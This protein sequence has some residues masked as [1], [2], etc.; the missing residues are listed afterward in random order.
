MYYPS[1]V[2][3]ERIN[4]DVTQHSTFSAPSLCVAKK[5][6]AYFQTGVLPESGTVCPADAKPLVGSWPSPS[7][8][9]SA[10]DH[11]LLS[12]IEDGISGWTYFNLARVW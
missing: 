7:Q 9:N 2:L 6:R 8:V 3:R 1:L 5:I 11:A 10:E 4:A 12:A